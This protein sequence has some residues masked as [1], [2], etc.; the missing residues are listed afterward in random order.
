VLACH[1]YTEAAQNMAAIAAHI[2]ALR[3]MLRHGVGTADQAFAGYAALPPPTGDAAPA[4]P[5]V[6][7]W[8]E[9]F[10]EWANA[11]DTTSDAEIRA[12]L[13]ETAFRNLSRKAH[14]DTG[15]SDAAMAELNAARDA[16]K[17]DF[18]A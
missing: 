6:R 13:I 18:G 4:A 11:I 9:V 5:R 3:T 1:R 12:A 8:R 16:A 15:G 2:D 14:P 7:A 10:G 17:K